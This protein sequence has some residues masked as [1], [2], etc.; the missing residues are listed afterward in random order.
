MANIRI[1]SFLANSEHMSVGNMGLKLRNLKS[2]ISQG[3]TEIFGGRIKSKEI[4]HWYSKNK[5]YTYD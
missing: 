1:L 2:V 5:S 4:N 3:T